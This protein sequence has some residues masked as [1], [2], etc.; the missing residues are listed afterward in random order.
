M[1]VSREFRWSEADP[2]RPERDGADAA[3][4]PRVGRTRGVRW[5][6][7]RHRRFTG[8]VLAAFG[9]ISAVVQFTGQL[10]PRSL[11]HPGWLTLLAL[12]GCLAWGLIRARRG[13]RI[14]RVF[15]QPGTTVVVAPGDLFDQPTQRVIGFSDTFDTGIG[16]TG[17]IDA[18]SLQG[19]L[20]DREYGGDVASLDRELAS[21]LR[22]IRPRTR[23]RRSA[24]PLG[25]LIRYPVGTAVVLGR[26]PRLVYAV[27]CSRIGNDGIAR[28]SVEEL[29]TSLHR[30]WDA[31]H[32]HGR[33]E[34]VAMPLLG[35]G[36]S[37]LDKVDVESLVRMIL[38]SFVLRSREQLISRELRIVLRPEDFARLDLCELE[39]LLE[40]L[41]PGPAAS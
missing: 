15:R 1:M 34:P 24:K 7:R 16:G 28:S 19:Q 14:S 18:A 10:F 9:G 32:L 3:R 13:S 2:T 30:L 29:G 38:L 37:R 12:G 36:L 5:F 26:R 27:A 39:A 4:R 17:L 40:A 6:S 11:A 20:L 23:E 31:V 33:L 8:E 35:A 21:A 25:K 41:E 22:G